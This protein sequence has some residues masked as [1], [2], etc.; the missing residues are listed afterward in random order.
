MVLQVG[1]M[2]SRDLGLKR[3]GTAK[4]PLL[5]RRREADQSG[6]PSNACCASKRSEL[7]DGY[8]LH[9]QETVLLQV[10]ATGCWHYNQEPRSGPLVQTHGYGALHRTLCRAPRPGPCGNMSQSWR[11]RCLQLW[12]FVHGSPAFRKG[13]LGLAAGGMRCIRFFLVLLPSFGRLMDN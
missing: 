1:K 10:M 7:S 12:G 3:L 9:S 4:R 8:R 2:L 6:A 5:R 13:L 11:S